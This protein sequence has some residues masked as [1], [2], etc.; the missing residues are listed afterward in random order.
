MLEGVHCCLGGLK[1]GKRIAQSEGK[2][3]SLEI[4]VVG[5]VVVNL[6]MGLLISVSSQPVKAMQSKRNKIE[7]KCI[8]KATEKERDTERWV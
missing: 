3:A 8:N 5:V 1:C 6:V 7:N 2:W 4:L